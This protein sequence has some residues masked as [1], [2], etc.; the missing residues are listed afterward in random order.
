MHV[1]ASR[2]QGFNPDTDFLVWAG[3]DTLAA[4]LVGML[5][6]ERE[7]YRF[8]WLRYERKR[9]DDG[10]RTDE[11]AA[12]VPITVDLRDPQIGL[13]THEDDDGPYK[14]KTA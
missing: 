8:Q 4:L 2:F 1:M 3:G 7:V 5:L 9:L 13:F 11:G 10:S 12:Y 14:A 6:M